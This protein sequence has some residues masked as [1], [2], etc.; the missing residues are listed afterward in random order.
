M[1]ALHE[2]AALE[3]DSSVVQIGFGCRFGGMESK[4]FIRLM[5]NSKFLSIIKNDGFE[6]SNAKVLIPIALRNLQVI[7]KP[8]HGPESTKIII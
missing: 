3:G 4:T 8:L 6:V 1:Q 7:P 2:A 5:S